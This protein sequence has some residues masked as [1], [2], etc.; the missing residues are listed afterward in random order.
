MLFKGKK[1]I[2][3]EQG[4]FVNNIKIEK[5]QQ[6][7]FLGVIIADNLSW[8]PH[9]DYIS[10]KVSKSIGILYRLSK[11]VNRATLISLYY[12][13]IYSYIIYCNEIWGLGYATHRKKLFSLQKRAVR[14]ICNKPKFEHTDPLFKELGILKVNDINS[15][16]ITNFMFKFHY[17]ELPNIFKD[18]F[19]Y[20]NSVHSHNTRQNYLL[21]VPIVRGNLTYMNIRYAGV[22]NWNKAARLLLHD[23]T[24]DT[25]KK[26]LKRMY[27][28]VY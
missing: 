14:I 20:N 25:F 10:K 4:I 21:H 19:T 5:T 15:F 26:R 7:K 22:V 3:T 17:N 13:L 12:S 16:L 9:I 11:Y 18:M 24:I 2:T 8:Q 23:C 28:D 6:A 27:V 1:H